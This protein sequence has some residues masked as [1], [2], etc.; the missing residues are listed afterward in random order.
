M[1][2]ASPPSYDKDVFLSITSDGGKPATVGYDLL[3]WRGNFEGAVDLSMFI[4]GETT[5]DINMKMYVR[6][7]FYSR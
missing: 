5:V 6:S 2:A 4:N 3:T 7:S 1:H